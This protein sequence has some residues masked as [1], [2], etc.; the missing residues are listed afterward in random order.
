[1]EMAYNGPHAVVDVPDAG[2]YGVKHG[3]PVE[4]ESA[5]VR[6]QLHRQGWSY[7]HDDDADS[8]NDKNSDDNSNTESEGDDE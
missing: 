1:M 7:V 5:H 8:D 3:E 4:V 6:G 2:L